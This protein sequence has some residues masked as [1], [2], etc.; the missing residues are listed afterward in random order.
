MANTLGRLFS[1]TSF[2]ESHGKIVGCLLEGCPAGL[3]LC[4]ADI[5]PDLDRRRPGRKDLA[6]HRNEPDRAE[7]WTGVYRGHSTG[8]PL[9]LVVQNSDIDSEAYESM[10][11][12]PRPGHADYGAFIKYGG[13]ADYRGGGRFSGRITAGFVMAGSVAKKLLNVLGMEVAAY[14]IEIGGIKAGAPD[15]K[16]PA[17][18]ARNPVCCVDQAAAEKMISAISNT[19]QE[20]DSLGG[21]IGITLT[22][23]PA[24]L[25]EPVVDTLDGELAKAFFCIPGV[26]GVDF[27]A[28]FDAARMKGSENND[29]FV[30]R[31]GRVETATNRAGG[32]LGGVSTGMPLVARVAVKPTPSISRHQNTVDLKTLT[33][34][35]L[36]IAGRHDP[37][38]VPRAVVVVEGVA[39]IVLCDF[40]IMA[41][42]LPR[43]LKWNS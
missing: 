24:G 9:C 39:A 16:S 33:E 22:G 43:V 38:I 20:G 4:E 36:S 26:K 34:V 7:I 37:C 25:G 41:G 30:L 21:I 18:L 32:V 29:A 2:G 3:P 11:F 35:E 19:R 17:E 28:G 6:S 40:C 42:L 8:A 12:T 27:G 23:V 31:N 15:E 10:R 14:T 13:W 5:Q 1:V